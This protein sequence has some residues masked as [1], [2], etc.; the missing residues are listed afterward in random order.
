MVSSASLVLLASAGCIHQ[1]NPA[2]YTAG[3]DLYTA[4]LA[5]YRAGHYGNAAKGFEDATLRFASLDTLLSRAYYYLGMSQIKNNE[6]ILAIATF[7]KLTQSFPTDTLA[8]DAMLESGKASAGL[9]SSPELDS[10][11]GEEALQTLSDLMGLYPNSPL[12]DQAAAEIVRLEEQFATKE[13]ETGMYYV[14]WG[15]LASSLESFKTV[16]AQYPMTAKAR[17]A[18]F[19]L[20]VVY[21]K[22]KWQDEL[23]GVCPDVRQLY[24]S[25]PKARELCGESPQAAASP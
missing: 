15:A 12:R 8:D 1:F 6:P 23:R 19:Q 11:H 18:Y 2:S 22:L 7:N 13:F 20:A 3:L 9:W 4:S 24:P 17:E 21:S 25:D 5:Q 16:I 14:R 10:K